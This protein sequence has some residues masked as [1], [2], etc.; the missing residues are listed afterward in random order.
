MAGSAGRKARGRAGFL[1]LSLVALALPVALGAS[2]ARAGDISPTTRGNGLRSLVNDPSFQCGAGACISGGTEARSNLFHR[3]NQFDTTGIDKVLIKTLGYGNDINNVIMGVINGKTVINTLVG[4]ES[5]ANLFWLSPGGISI[6]GAGG[7][8]NV[9]Q[10]SLSTAKKLEIG[11]GVFNVFD[12]IDLEA[13]QLT[14]TPGAFV[15]DLPGGNGDIILD[16]AEGSVLEVDSSLLLDAQGGNVLFQNTGLFPGDN[17]I[18][19]TSSSG[20]SARVSGPAT[21]SGGE[22]TI[23]RPPSSTPLAYNF[24][25]DG[26]L[27]LRGPASAI[28]GSANVETNGPFVW[29]DGAS[30]RGTGALTTNGASTLSGGQRLTIEKPVWINRGRLEFIDQTSLLFPKGGIWANDSAG[31][32]LLDNG[33]V[34]PTLVVADNRASSFNLT[35]TNSGLIRKSS[36]TDQGLELSRFVNRGTGT[37]ALENGSLAIDSTSTVQAGNI[38]LSDSISSSPVLIL[39]S[40]SNSDIQN[41][42][43]IS[44]NGAL[45]LG[46]LGIGKLINT[47]DPLLQNFGQVSPGGGSPGG[48]GA[49]RIVIEGSYV[50]EQGSSL[51]LDIGG[52]APGASDQLVVT[53]KADLPAGTLN[54]GLIGGYVPAQG[55]SIEVLRAD[56]GLTIGQGLVQSLPP[57]VAP[58]TSDN[59]YSLVIQ[60]PPVD[61][62]R[63]TP[64]QPPVIPPTPPVQPPEPP[65][66][67]VPPEPPPITPPP[68]T[69]PVVPD[70][71]VVIPPVVTNPPPPR[72]A[73]PDEPDLFEPLVIDQKQFLLTALAS[74]G[75]TGAAGSLGLLQLEVEEASFSSSGEPSATGAASGRGAGAPTALSAQQTRENFL[76]GETQAQVDTAAKLGLAEGAGGPAP[77][78]ERLQC[79]LREA[80]DWVRTGQTS[81]QGRPEEEDPCRS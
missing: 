17:R 71:P 72:P 32:I 73:P 74:P 67:V 13:A 8:K 79:L 77:T 40:A 62:G 45:R 60:P 64:P 57:N 46:P 15:S 24:A 39:G 58:L 48:S 28:G 35:I 63:P 34:L 20:G 19:F 7:F 26:S 68:V 59:T 54:S 76:Q 43:T 36:S 16:L 1:G 33:A 12:T 52:P 81:A 31:E 22:L 70:P 50:Q 29:A 75:L 49:G 55:D 21:I 9:G 4:L 27:S 23:D 11:A 38:A 37:I 25:F 6:T 41:L 69:P 61:P 2:P 18:V 65:I 10:L 30:I 80:T 53:G 56:A 14:G 66:V 3:F 51:R 42:G 5:K 44:G 47:G 78:P